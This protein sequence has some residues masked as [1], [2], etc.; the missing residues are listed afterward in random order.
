MKTTTLL[1]ISFMAYISANAQ[2]I[3]ILKSGEELNA[4]VLEVGTQDIKYKK[5]EN[6]EGPFYTISKDKLFMIKYQ[7]GT[8]ETFGNSNIENTASKPNIKT[9][10]AQQATTNS[11]SDSQHKLQKG[12]VL[13]GLGTSFTTVGSALLIA[14]GVVF[15]NSYYNYYPYDDIAESN[16]IIMMSVGSAV[17]VAGLPMMISGLVKMGAAKKEIRL[18]KNSATSL[19]I[20][21]TLLLN[22]SKQGSTPGLYLGMR[23]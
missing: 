22:H 17:F 1:L 4:K 9:A 15:G 3:L 5:F 7:N 14:G 18:S 8:K 13:T 10:V 21:P 11:Y 12:K 6:P 19:Q 20:S 2:D 23:F 16:G